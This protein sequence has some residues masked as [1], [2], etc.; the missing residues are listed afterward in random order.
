MQKSQKKIGRKI[1]LFIATVFAIAFLLVLPDSGIAN[2]TQKQLSLSEKISKA[3]KG[4]FVLEIKSPTGEPIKNAVVSVRQTRHEFKFGGA[5]FT[6]VFDFSQKEREKKK[7]L[8]IADKWFNIIVDGNGFKWKNIE[9]SPGKIEYGFF[10]HNQVIKWA[11]EH[12]KDIRHHTLFWS[13]PLKNPKWV[14]D[15]RG[16][17]L[18]KAIFNRIEYTKKMAGPDIQYLDVVNEMLYYGFF[19]DHAGQDIIPEIF[20]ECR[21]AFPKAR[22]YLNEFPPQKGNDFSVFDNYVNLINEMKKKDAPFDGIGLQA[23]YDVHEIARLGF[24][25]DEFMAK[26][27]NAIDKLAKSA[28]MPVFI[29]EYDAVSKNERLRAEFLKAFYTM[30]FANKNVEG[31]IFWEWIDTGKHRALVNQDGSKTLAGKQYEA[32]VLGK[33]QTNK[34]L[35]TGSDG[36]AKVHAFF[37]DY[38]ITLEKHGHQQVVNATLGKDTPQNVLIVF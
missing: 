36:K 6:P 11:K 17:D 33:W 12:N 2:D 9:R 18:K 10:R 30:A 24:G 7:V 21:K 4:H 26:M 34:R 25:L 20:A 13:N 14:R 37:G 28:D 31:I 16:N 23:H 22:L 32:L 19:R 35:V 15:L 8:Q 5:L 27:D 3:R 38:E 1:S 29:T